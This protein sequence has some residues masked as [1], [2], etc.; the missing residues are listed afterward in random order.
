MR[1][2]VTATVVGIGIGGALL[3]RANADGLP[4]LPAPAEPSATASTSTSTSTPTPTPTSTPTSSSSSTAPGPEAAPPY[5]L[6]RSAPRFFTFSLGLGV[7]R[8][9]GPNS[10]AGAGGLYV[11]AEYWAQPFSWLNLRSYLGY[12]STSTD[13]R[14]CYRID[15]C[16]VSENIGLLGAKVRLV[17]PI[18]WVAPFFELGLGVSFGDIHAT[19]VDSDLTT[20]GVVLDVPVGLGLSIGPRHDVDVSLLSLSHGGAHAIGGALLVGVNVAAP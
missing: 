15:G 13:Q 19:D 2:L 1:T 11:S 12:L 9:T 7:S 16:D 10:K 17:A 6:R 18:P 8:A 14:N 3:G 20:H 5:E 4:P